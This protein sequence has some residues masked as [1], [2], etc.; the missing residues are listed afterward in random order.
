MYISY[1]PLFKPVELISG[2]SGSNEGMWVWKSKANDNIQLYSRGQ[3]ALERLAAATK[4]PDAKEVL[5][6]LPAFFCEVS[7][8]PLRYGSYKIVFY[9]LDSLLH[10]ELS[11]IETLTH[12]HGVPNILVVVHYFGIPTPIEEVKIWGEARGVQVVEDAA[13]SLLPVPGIG[14][15]ELPV[16]YTPWKFFGLRE[17]ALLLTPNIAVVRPDEPRLVSMQQADYRWL[18]KQ[19]VLSVLVRGLKIPLHRVRSV[20][21]KGPGESEPYIKPGPVGCTWFGNRM[22]SGILTAIPVAAKNREANYRLM[23]KIL[24]DS[25]LAEGLFS[26]TLP[27]NFAPYCFPCLVGESRAQSLMIRLCKEGLMSFP[28]SDL[29]PE[30]KDND[31]YLRENTW[32]RGIITLPIHQDLSTEQVRGIAC[33]V[34]ELYENM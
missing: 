15:N 8:A 7:L 16:I 33:R 17:G 27:K 30:V 26:D 14:D 21:V 22:L 10:P 31:T 18:A 5:I 19:A 23:H 9:R 2:V 25:V 11:H 24:S 13:H 29:S 12:C 20:Y 3:W 34:V 28:W 32:R 4:F 6:F 1:N